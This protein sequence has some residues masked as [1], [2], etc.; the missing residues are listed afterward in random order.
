MQKILF[1]L[2]FL[3]STF[4]TNAQ[5]FEQHPTTLSGYFDF[6]SSGAAPSFLIHPTPYDSFRAIYLSTVSND[7]KSDLQIGYTTSSDGYSWNGSYIIHPPIAGNQALDIWQG[8]PVIAFDRLIGDTAISTIFIYPDTEIQLPRFYAYYEPINPRMAATANGNL[9]IVCSRRVPSAVYKLTFNTQL[10]GSW[11]QP[12]PFLHFGDEYLVV[13]NDS[14]RVAIVWSNSDSVGFFESYDNGET[15]NS[16]NIVFASQIIKGDLI[17]PRKGLDAVY[18]GNALYIVWS[19]IG[20]TPRSARILSWNPIGGML[21]V[22]DSSRL[23]ETLASSMNPLDDHTVIDRPT[24]GRYE[25]AASVGCAFVVFKKGE[26]DSAGWNYGDIYINPGGYFNGWGY[27]WN[28]TNTPTIDDR[29]PE[30]TPT[31]TPAWG[32]FLVAYQSDTIPGSNLLRGLQS[33]VI[34]N[35]QWAGVIDL[36]VDETSKLPANP[37]LYQNYPN[38]F[39]PRTILRYTITRP[40]HVRIIVYDLL[41][42]ELAELVTWEQSP[43][44][45][46]IHWDAA[47]LASGMYFY[48]IITPESTQIKKMLLLR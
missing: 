5:I 28:I 16:S 12:L 9:V 45:R 43:G 14:G 17:K 27:S 44:T 8:K 1:P 7:Y 35:A 6:Q 13:G 36:S 21:T 42:R 48:R 25:G 39:N 18:V 41:G 15:F 34:Q 2:I 33:K 10:N 4:K 20:S 46:E 32:L 26:I 3:L 30:I 31:N 29:Y 37:V 22:V 23:S 38:P 11:S 47:G 19:A 40:S 24:I